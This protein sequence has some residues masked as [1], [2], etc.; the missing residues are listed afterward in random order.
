MLPGPVS[1]FLRHLLIDR[2]EPL[3]PSSLSKPADAPLLHPC[4]QQRMQICRAGTD[5]R[6]SACHPAGTLFLQ[7]VKQLNSA[8]ELWF[9]SFSPS[10]FWQSPICWQKSQRRQQTK[11]PQA[12]AAPQQPVAHPI[13]PP[14]RCGSPQGLRSPEPSVPGGM[15]H[16][17]HCREGGCDTRGRR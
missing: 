3:T 11:P 17:G 1:V 14:P 10:T 2:A 4:A 6:T 9:T 8:V 7:H 5:T 12:G 16:S 15:G 13:C